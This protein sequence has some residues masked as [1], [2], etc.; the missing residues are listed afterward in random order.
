M[1]LLQRLIIVVSFFACISMIYAGLELVDRPARA[2]AAT[3]CEWSS[4]CP[5]KQ[6]C[7]LPGVRANC[8]NPNNSNCAGVNY[9]E[10]PRLSD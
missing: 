1:K 2:E 8:C 3:C 4:Q 6:V 10:E 5:G 7:Y 9:C